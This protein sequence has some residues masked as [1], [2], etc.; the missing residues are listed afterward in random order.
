MIP[1]MPRIPRQYADQTSLPMRRRPPPHPSPPVIRPIE[2]PLPFEMAAAGPSSPSRRHRPRMPPVR[3]DRHRSPY[4]MPAMSFGGALLS[5]ARA[6]AAQER[7]DELQART[8]APGFFRR[9]LG[10]LLTPRLPQQDEDERLALLLS[11][12]DDA[13]AE[14]WRDQVLRLRLFGTGARTGYEELQQQPREEEYKPE[15][16]HPTPPEPSYTFDFAVPSSPVSGSRSFFPPSSKD[17]PIIVGDDEPEAGP[18]SS[19]KQSA[20]SDPPKINALLICACCLDP[21]V[22]NAGLSPEDAKDRRVWGLRCGHLIDGK[23]LAEIGQPQPEQAQVDV[24][25]KRKANPRS[26]VALQPYGDYDEEGVRPSC[27]HT[28]SLPPENNSIRSR[29]RSR[30]HLQMLA[31]PQS[32]PS[33]SHASPSSSP[34]SVPPPPL[35]PPKQRKRPAK[36]TAHKKRRIEDTFAWPCPIASCGKLHYSVKI[37]GVWGPE[38]EG[39]VKGSEPRGA[40]AIFA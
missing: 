4:H 35:Q 13:R 31:Q 9:S 26:T 6:R 33:S 28:S 15:Y 16:T 34:F 8:A 10:R 32:Q 23:C 7:L 27:E 21:L 25:G 17:A 2:Q 40:I 29:L 3:M 39:L 24:K 22:L 18:S 1:P 30:P 37:N 5:S 19:S 11:L 14:N 12:Q 20:P 38:K 36:T